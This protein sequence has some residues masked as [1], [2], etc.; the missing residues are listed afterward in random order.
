MGIL[1]EVGLLAAGFYSKATKAPEKAQ[2]GA[3]V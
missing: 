2:D 3:G 1:Y